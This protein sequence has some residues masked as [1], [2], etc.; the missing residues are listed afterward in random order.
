MK[1]EDISQYGKNKQGLPEKFTSELIAETWG[2][3]NRCRNEWQE[4]GLRVEGTH[5]KKRKT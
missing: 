5:S 4:V 2:K 1:T 3:V